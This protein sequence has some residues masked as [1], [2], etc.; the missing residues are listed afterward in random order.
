MV[1]N[2]SNRNHP[3]NMNGKYYSEKLT[4]KIFVGQYIKRNLMMP[5]HLQY[6]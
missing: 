4:V 1:M 6:L 2:S 3:V 5:I